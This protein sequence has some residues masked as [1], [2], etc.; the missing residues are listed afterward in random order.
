[1]KRSRNFYLEEEE[2]EEEYKENKKS[3]KF[4]E[5]LDDINLKFLSKNLL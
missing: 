4:D 3:V 2:E 1:M 5:N